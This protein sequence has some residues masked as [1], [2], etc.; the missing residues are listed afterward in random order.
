MS[1]TITITGHDPAAGGERADEA[2][3]QLL[4]RARTFVSDLPGV[5]SAAITTAASGTVD[6]LAQA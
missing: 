1:Y 4:H 6:L 5:S 2:E 3:Q